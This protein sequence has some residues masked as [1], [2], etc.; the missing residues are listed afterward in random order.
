MAALA[1]V[2]AAHEGERCDFDDAGGDRTFDLVAGDHVIERVI[3]RAE[4]RIDLFLHVARQ[5]AKALAG[6]DGRTGQDDAI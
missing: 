1:S 2:R 4:I 5:E 6:F 3:E